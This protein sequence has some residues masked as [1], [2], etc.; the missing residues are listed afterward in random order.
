MKRVPTFRLFALLAASALSVS[1]ALTPSA[2]DALVAPYLQVQTALAADDLATAQAATRA[3]AA[4]AAGPEELDA[5]RTEISRML[6]TEELEKARA[7]FLPVSREFQQLLE[8]VGT[9][10]PSPLHVAFCPMALGYTGG[11]WI[12]EGKTVMNPYEGSRMLHCG[13]IQQTLEKPEK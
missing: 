10:H 4:A 13:V 12:Q 1:A 8:T 9:S 11:T 2:V 5:L 7:A 6:A 3:L